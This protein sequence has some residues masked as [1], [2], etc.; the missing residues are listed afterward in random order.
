M[1]VTAPVTNYSDALA[2][3][4]ALKN[5]SA[6]KQSND[7]LGKDDFLKI[8]IS[9]MK[10]QDPLEPMKDKEFIAQMAQ[11]SSVEQMTNMASSQASMLNEIKMLRASLGAM[12]SM[13]GK[14]VYWLDENAQMQNGV[15]KAVSVKDGNTNLM[16]NGKP[17]PLE[18]V[19]LVAQTEGLGS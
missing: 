4:Q 18:K 12:S 6:V 14:Q 5:P 19:E 1:A 7:R 10:N 17:V 11:F 3:S 2:R 15:V 13:I 8:L 9:Q 16:V